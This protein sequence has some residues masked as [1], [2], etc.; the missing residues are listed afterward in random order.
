MFSCLSNNKYATLWFMCLKLISFLF[1]MNS[2]CN[3][4]SEILTCTHSLFWGLFCIA[5][6]FIFS[7][8]HL[9]LSNW[10]NISFIF[11]ADRPDQKGDQICQ[12][13]TQN[14]QVLALLILTSLSYAQLINKSKLANQLN[15]IEYYLE[16]TWNTKKI[17]LIALHVEA[18]MKIEHRK[19]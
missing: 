9:L 18:F 12:N 15:S 13:S 7:I 3:L 10:L 1:S 14:L 6:Y 8:L 16:Q 19:L 4:K 17:E 2:Y 5:F 11:W